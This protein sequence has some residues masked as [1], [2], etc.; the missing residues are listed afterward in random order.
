[1]QAETDIDQEGPHLL[2]KQVQILPAEGSP[3]RTLLPNPVQTAV[4]SIAL[5][6]EAATRALGQRLGRQLEPGDVLLLEGDL[7]AGKTTLVQGLAAGLGIAEPAVSPTF[8]LLHELAGPVPLRHLDLY[9]LS[10]GD[11]VHLGAE[12]WFEPDAVVAIEWAD[13]LGPYRPREFLEIALETEGQGRRARFV[14]VG[15]RYERLA[16]DLQALKAEA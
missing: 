4:D 15:A 3:V 8:A 1:M 14:A 13:R 2:Q 5:P 9:R 16:S 10:P 11:L 12:E 7:G 6:D